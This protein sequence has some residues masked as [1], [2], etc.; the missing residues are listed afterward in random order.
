MDQPEK[1]HQDVLA[2]YAGEKH[3]IVC[4]TITIGGLSVALCNV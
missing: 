2:F 4:I 3:G 1:Y